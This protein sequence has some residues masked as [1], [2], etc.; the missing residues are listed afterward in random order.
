MITIN[1]LKNHPQHI[2]KLAEIWQNVLGKIWVPDIPIEN[3]ITKLSNHLHDNELPLTFIALDGDHPV[4]MCSLREN[5]GIRPDLTPWLGSLV[6]DPLYQKQGVAKIL[7]N[8]TI[9]KAKSFEFQKL[10]LFAFDPTIPDYY[11]RLGWKIIGVDE[12]KSHR[13][14]VMSKDL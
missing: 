8:A 11:A 14:E 9:E 13:V 4:G 7:I 1:Y 12:F 2:H 3:V 10:Y 6:I 5:D